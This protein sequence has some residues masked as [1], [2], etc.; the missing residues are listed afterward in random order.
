M[1]LLLLLILLAPVP[2][3]FRTRQLPDMKTADNAELKYWAEDFTRFKKLV[4]ATG[5]VFDA[6]ARGVV[7]NR[8]G[9]Y[10]LTPAVSRYWLLKHARECA[11]G[12]KSISDPDD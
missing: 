8:E 3:E 2:K 10:N 11:G 5:I 4:D 9:W 6:A 7:M 12:R 1:N